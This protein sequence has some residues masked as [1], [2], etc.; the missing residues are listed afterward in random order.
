ML[1]EKRKKKTNGFLRQNA[2]FKNDYVPTESDYLPLHDDVTSK[3][4]KTKQPTR[5]DVHKLDRVTQIL[6]PILY[7]IFLACYFGYYSNVERK[8]VNMVAFKS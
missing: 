6:L 3:P 4:T 2:V 8:N 5:P 7:L 1:E